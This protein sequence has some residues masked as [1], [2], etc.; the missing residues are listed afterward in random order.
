MASKVERTEIHHSKEHGWHLDILPK[1]SIFAYIVLAPN[2]NEG[3]TKEWLEKLDDC[4][5]LTKG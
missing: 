3:N 5:G 1:N 2:P 4:L